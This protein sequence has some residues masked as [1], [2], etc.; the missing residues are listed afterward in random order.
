MHL[1]CWA[2]ADGFTIWFVTLLLEILSHESC[3]GRVFCTKDTLNSF[4]GTSQTFQK[5]KS[6]FKVWENF[7]VLSVVF[8]MHLH[9]VFICKQKKKK[10]SINILLVWTR[11]QYR[12]KEKNNWKYTQKSFVI[13]KYVSF[14][15]FLFFRLCKIPIKLDDEQRKCVCVC[16]N[17]EKWS[18]AGKHEPNDYYQDYLQYKHKTL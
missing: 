13:Q 7:V 16:E 18:L 9:N 17:I 8:R 6:Y 2:R 10:N 5:T 1:F 4:F 3:V 14:F 12:I 11:R 15:L